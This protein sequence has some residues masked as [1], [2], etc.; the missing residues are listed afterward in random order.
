MSNPAVPADGDPGPEA[1][2]CNV[3]LFIGDGMGDA[4][5]TMARNYL[6]GAGGRLAM[7]GLPFTGSATTY[8]VRAGDP[9]TAV[10]VTDSAAAA[11][12][13]STGTKTS[14]GAIGVDAYGRARP[15]LAELARDGGLRTGIVT[16]EELSDPTPAAMGAHV[17]D[18]SGQG[19]DSMDRCPAQ[20]REHG[21]PGSI[22]EQLARSRIDL[23]LGGGLRHFRQTVRDGAH[24]P[25][26]VLDEAAAHGYS[27]VTGTA[28]LKR[29]R[30]GDRLLGLFADG[31]LERRWQGPLALPGDSAPAA[32]RPNPDVPRQQPGLAAMVAE[33]LRLLGPATPR[34]PGFFLLA[35]SAQIDNAGHDAD[36]CGV[37]GEVGALDEAV[38]TGLDYAAGRSD[39][40]VIVTADHGHSCQIVPVDVACPGSSAVLRTPEGGTM[41]VNYS[42]NLPGEIMVHTGAQV[43]VAAYGPGARAVAGLIDHTDLFTLIRRALTGG[44]G[45]VRPAHAA[46]RPLPL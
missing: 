39:T 4:E 21:G 27:L 40:L 5:L 14:N 23:L 25:R 24:A 18:R 28:E 16:T 8:S 45:G 19:P 1:R 37:I 29:R 17:A 6:A 13:W 2:P 30:P 35:E 9:R 11:T 10:Y 26:T 32:C 33:A 20:A 46:A 12:A 34:D 36:P 3:L 42:T 22:A 44:R 7:D 31:P 15:T 41:K 43:R 38:R